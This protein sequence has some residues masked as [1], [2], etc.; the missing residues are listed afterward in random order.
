MVSSNQ[1][2][3]LDDYSKRFQQVEL[4]KDSLY[5]SFIKRRRRNDLKSK[6]VMH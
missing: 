5:S 1:D 3:F 4:T 2:F 6:E